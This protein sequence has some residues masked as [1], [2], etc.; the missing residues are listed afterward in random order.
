MPR[1]GPPRPADPRGADLEDSYREFRLP[2]LVLAVS[3]FVAGLLDAFAFL[4]YG[5]FAANQSGNAVLLGVGLAGEYPAWPGAAASL[6]AFAAGA[7]AT[8]RLRA[9]RGRRAPAAR[10]LAAAVVTVWLWAALNVLFE[11]GRGGPHPR[12]GLAAAGGFAMGCLATLF[13]RTAGIATTITYQ[14]GTVAKTGERL[15][16]WLTGPGVDR[17][18][19]RRAAL[20]GLLTLACYTAG[21]GV[22]TLAQQRPLW[23]PAW[24]SLALVAVAPLLRRR[25]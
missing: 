4:R 8:S 9:A 14:S 3:T 10:G 25:S 6:V 15:A 18:A 2:L 24:G 16:A 17:S 22:G 1:P 5:V 12:V 13:V 7:G 23:V 11:Y 21:G 20:L 19:A